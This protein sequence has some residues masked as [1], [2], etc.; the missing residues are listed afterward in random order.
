MKTHSLFILLFFAIGLGAQPIKSYKFED[1]LA[2][3]DDQIEL[4]DYFNALE[5][6]RN[7]YKEVKSDDVALSIAFSYYKMRDFENAE[8]WYSRVLD[9]DE[10]N[11]FIDD[12]YAYG[13]VL[14]SMENPAKAK[15]QFE[16]FLAMSD[17]AELRRLAQIEL[18]GME[19]ST[20]F[21][22]NP[23]LVVTFGSDKINSGS[24]EYS[25][26]DY[27]DETL[28]FG[29]FQRRREVILD[30][31]EKD[32]EV[33]IYSAKKGENGIE[34]P[35]P[36]NKR[37]NREDFHTSNVC[38]SRDRRKMYFTRQQLQNDQILSST[39]YVSEMGDSDWRAPVPLQQVNG[40]FLS[41][42]PA[43]GELFGDEV[44]FF[45]SDMDGGLGGL[46]IYYSTINGDVVG[47]PVNLGEAIN[48]VDDDITPQYH[49]GNL[50]FSTEGRPG[51]GG[52]D[53]FKSVWDGS[54]W[55][56][57]INM[58]LQYNSLFDDFHL[59]YAQDGKRGY[60]VSN[61]PDSNKKKLKSETCCFDIYDFYIRETII[62]LLVGVGTEDEK[63]LDG[64]TVELRDLTVYSD[65]QSQTDPKEYR[66]TFPLDGDRKYKVI[67][68]KEGYFPDTL[69][70]NTNGIEED[71][72]IRKKVLLKKKATEPEYITETVTINEPIRLNNIYY[73]FDKWDILP[74]AEKDL[75]ILLDLMNEYEDMVIELSSHTDS[76]GPTPYNEDLSQKRAQS[77]TDWLID[78]GV[79]SE[80]IVPKG[81]GESVILNRCV[82]GVRCPDEEHM[83]NRRTEFKIIAG[84][85]TI[86]IRREVTKEKE[87]EYKGGKQ[88][89]NPDSF[90]EISFKNSGFIDLGQIREG[91]KRRLVYEF[92]NT[93]N[94]ELEIDLVTACQC[95]EISWPDEPIQPGESGKIVAIFDSSEM[96]GSVT[97]TM[98]IIAN[99]NPIVVEAK[100]SVE[101]IVLN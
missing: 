45:V 85:E 90:P 2:T 10:D 48:T 43:I 36:L 12:R 92:I 62:D 3:A 21:E 11:I 22:P 91:E 83:F 18:D 53:L 4:G 38:F 95:T 55:S 42:H 97:K 79:N 49:D 100:F 50:Y 96:E 77:A 78:K 70:F 52:Y 37:I 87:E 56:E 31:S 67:T 15:Q 68:S 40:S 71:K 5:W 44:L 39:I 64:A 32:F 61:R 24:G 65:P 41:L 30:G 88:S 28:Y 86:E 89:Y 81:Y 34:K 75:T 35:Q 60:L 66:Y 54:Q 25:P 6:Y 33:K 16:L 93:G 58:G 99:T 46:D 82:N 73:E 23:D 7:A 8:R 19:E 20:S 84:P 101:I 69:E 59:W 63:P 29:S 98:D 94:K 14:R 9:D 17:D 1:M 51:F 26:I 13:R 27:D 74:D 57:P 72:T 47:Q 80:R 76:Q